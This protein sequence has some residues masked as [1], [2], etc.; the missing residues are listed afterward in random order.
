MELKNQLKVWRAKQDITQGDLAL[1]VGLS[2]QSI[3]SIERG[4]Y[5]PSVISAMKLAA[6]FKTTVEDIF[7]FEEEK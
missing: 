2:R 1:E 3:N 6:F 5:V 4:I 7:Y